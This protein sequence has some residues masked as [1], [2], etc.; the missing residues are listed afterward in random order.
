[1]AVSGSTKQAAD[2]AMANWRL[3]EDRHALVT[4]LRADIESDLQAGIEA[5]GQASWAVSGGS[6]PKPLFEAM[7]QSPLDWRHIDVAL[8]D[9]RW[10]PFEHPRSNEAFVSESLQRGRAADARL[11]GMKTDHENAAAAVAEVNE[12]YA[13]LNQPFNS[14]L[15]G[16]GPDGHTASLFPGAEGLEPAFSEDAPLCVALT[17]QQSVVTGEEVERMS[18]SARAIADADHVVV[19]ITGDQKKRVL[20]DALKPNSGLPV[21]RLHAMTPFDV[22]WAP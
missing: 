12:R 4:A 11:F 8:V 21:G 3:F 16:V 19:M 1:M 17:A 14:V 9:E 18:L 15:L 5:G 20:E 2:L 6:T 7:Q 10:V 22:Y 13:R